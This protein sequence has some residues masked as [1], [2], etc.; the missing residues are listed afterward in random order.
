MSDVFISYARATEPEAVRVADALA[1]AGY[2][3]WRDDQLSTSQSYGDEIAARLEAAKAVV[4]L[5]SADA[6]KSQWVRAEADR[7]RAANK[8][9]QVNLDGARLPMP[10][11]QI[12]CADIRGWRGA[13]DAPGWRQTLASVAKLVDSQGVSHLAPAGSS[14]PSTP[15]SASG[16][17]PSIAAL[18]FANLS[19]DPE[20]DYFVDGLMEE[21]VTALTR[22]GRC[23][24]STPAPASASRGRRFRPRKPPRSWACAMCSR[25][26]SARPDSACG[27]R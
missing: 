11:D 5:W 3:V 22:I 27:Y 16:D 15:F 17:K 10:F 24:S 19:N 18:P 4:V 8:L 2:C 13:P 25:A 9:V 21:I 23:S 6:I 14:P 1:S 12:H 20:Q 26:V 7:A